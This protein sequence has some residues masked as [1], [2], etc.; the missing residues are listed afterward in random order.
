MLQVLIDTLAER[1]QATHATPPTDHLT[2][3]QQA[4]EM[5]AQTIERMLQHLGLQTQ[6]EEV[7]Q[8]QAVEALV[9]Y[10][11]AALQ[12]QALAVM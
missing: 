9:R 3:T 1:L 6:Y 7:L 2:D 8:A 4:R 12:D 10:A 11:E 5:Y